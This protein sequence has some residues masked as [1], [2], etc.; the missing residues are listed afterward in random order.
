MVPAL[1]F[2]PYV[3]GLTPSFFHIANLWK[4][5]TTEG[6]M[7][8]HL[9][10]SLLLVFP[11]VIRHL[12]HRFGAAIRTSRLTPIPILLLRNGDCFIG[13][14]RMVG[15]R[16]ELGLA[17]LGTSE[18]LYGYIDFGVRGSNSNPKSIPNLT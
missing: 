10:L 11:R 9:V 18:I 5:T 14:R 17:Y 15:F 16:L 3:L 1:S 4:K 6:M 13:R 7:N 8:S 12:T 2:V